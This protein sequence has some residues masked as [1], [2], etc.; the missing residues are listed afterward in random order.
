M[1]RLS[2]AL[3]L[4]VAP[5][6]CTG[7]NTPDQ[8]PPQTLAQAPDD[9]AVGEIPNVRPPGPP[10]APMPEVQPPA[11]DDDPDACGASRFQHLIGQPEAAARS[12]GLPQPLR[13]LCHNCPATMDYVPDRMTV[14][15]DPQGDV[16]QVSCG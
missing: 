14:T 12:A 15:L 8:D 16:A 13:I 11:I 4:A 6:A 1:I 5:M 10:A 3:L 7:S 9:P 2:L